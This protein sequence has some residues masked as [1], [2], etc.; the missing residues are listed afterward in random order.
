LKI[1]D[2]ISKIPDGTSTM[3][4][5]EEL[6]KTDVILWCAL[7]R[8]VKSESLIF[9]NA[10]NLSE[11]SLGEVKQTLLQ[12]DYE[13]ELKNRLNH[14]RPFLKQ[15]LRDD[16]PH[17]AIEKGRQM[18]VSENMV[19]EEIHFAINHPGTKLL[20]TFPREKQLI[21][22][23]I[24]RIAP[25]F[26]ETPRL[27]AMLGIPNQ[28]FNKR[29]GDSY[30]ML[31]SAWESNLGEGIDADMVVLDEKDRM[32]DKIEFAFRECLKSSKF[33]LMRELSTPTLPNCGIDVQFRAS[34][35]MVWMVK[36][37]KCGEFQE[38]TH[39]DNIIQMENFPIGTKELPPESYAYLCKKVKC[40]GKL[41]RVFTGQ[42]VAKYPDRRLIRGYHIPQLIAP[43]ISA[44][45][46]MQD[47]I[48]LRYPEIWLNYVIGVPAT[49]DL[50]MITDDDCSR[51]C[52]GHQFILER[53]KDWSHITV[54]IDWGNCHD[55]QTKILT[56]ER[57]F[58]YFKDLHPEDKVA[59]WD[60][61]TREM[62]FV[63]PLSITKKPFKGPLIHLTGKGIDVMVTPDHR[64]RVG[65]RAGHWITEPARTLFDRQETL[66]VGA[67][68]WE[69]REVDDFVLPGLP[70][71][72]G[73]KGCDPLK[74]TMDLWLEFLGYF[75]SEGGLCFDRSNGNE[76]P[77]CIKMSQR[78]S[79]HPKNVK[80]MRRCL[81]RLGLLFS[82]FP[83]KKTTDVN[84]TI[85]GKQLWSW[86]IDHVGSTCSTKRI[87]RAFFNLSKRQLA[88]LF[89]AMM[90]GDGGFS[91]NGGLYRSTSRGL[92]EDFMEIC[93]RLGLRASVYRL[94]KAKGKKK[95][96]WA[97]GWTDGKD[98]FLAR[99][100]EH[101]EHV[102][103]DGTV[104]CCTVSTGYIV[105]ERNGMVAYQGNCSWCVV[106]GRSAIN[107][108][109][110]ILNIGV[111][112][113]TS[114]A[115]EST[116]MM[117][118]FITPY[119]PDIVVADAGY[120][121]DRNSYLL[122]KLCPNG[123]EG[124]FYAQWYNPSQKSSRTFVPEWSD[125][126][127]ARVLVDRTLALKNLCRAVKDRE[128]GFPHLGIDKVQLLIRHL[129]A[130]APF[131]EVDE[132]TK[133][134][135]ETIKS[136]GDDHLSHALSSAI[137]GQEKLGKQTRFSFEFMG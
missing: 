75:L 4:A 61:D 127:R 135:I 124:R 112:E 85:Y 26:T 27:A 33:G 116:A 117:E 107:Q 65:S 111:F 43:W 53:T 133:E 134:I 94:R 22:F 136:S 105:T 46:V 72:P 57:G 8:R 90:L 38:I 73:Y 128:F 48:D 30:L 76:R 10:R 31:R 47:K 109:L 104:Y 87:P 84:W 45:R 18:G 131:R 7:N 42:W 58:V 121:K 21:D 12:S 6:A 35:Q 40:R 37:E 95:A 2:L 59:Q 89:D 60:A 71:S 50:E 63:R 23:S 132:Q 119:V 11:E 66:F 54:G 98:R 67:L 16:H 97:C 86:I 110:Y 99:A 32:R 68:D 120:G 51:A 1:A 96:V 28:I 82:E 29:I 93:I 130:L 34:D 88:I 118:R 39:T 41:D 3:A 52:A 108:R 25:V 24:T 91:G 113:D 101:V 137:L 103:Y 102:P 56:E 36:C 17:K 77:S 129:K 79:V 13:K 114:N 122:R 62:S 64:M 80:K 55:D 125:P 100:S 19:S 14:H 69:G 78:E 44:T 49:S 106:L 115:L 20:H 123:T 92:C 5:L 126:Q 81:K 74:V 9:D 15:P 70:R 83:N